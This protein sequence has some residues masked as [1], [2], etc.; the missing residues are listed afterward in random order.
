MAS[1]VA[2]LMIE[3]VHTLAE[4]EAIIERGMQSFVEVGEAL[5][6]IKEG[7][8]YADEFDSFED[9]CKVRWGM[10]Y[11]F[12]MRHIAAS[13][14][15]TIV[16]THGLPAPPTIEAAKPLIRV[17]NEA[18]HYDSATK[19]LR[20]PKAAEKAVVGVMRKV[21]RA[22]EKEAAA[23][24]EAK[25][26]PITGRDVQKVVSPSAST[27]KPGWHELAGAAADHL[28]AADRELTR[29]EHEV[30]IE[31]VRFRA[32]CWER[33]ISTET[34]EEKATRYAAMA[35]DLAD[36]FTAIAKEEQ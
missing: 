2:D 5:A 12:A 14:V 30:E 9:Y 7:A 20:N 1:A 21:V 28:I 25:P 13:Q 31:P 34:L 36:R 15:S 11:A 19:T 29:L 32:A 16:E 18:G 27:R 26:K 33:V 10:G 22:K 4:E 17:M 6:R 8:L 24:P 23:D 35:R 3:P